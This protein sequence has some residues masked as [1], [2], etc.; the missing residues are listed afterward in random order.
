MSLFGDYIKER[1]NKEIVEDSTGFATYSYLPQGVYIQ[2]IY[3]APDY[4][5]AGTAA[6]FA[7]QIAVIAKEKGH[8]KMYGSVMPSA[9]GATSSLKVLLAYG[10]QLDS[11]G[12]NAIIMVKDI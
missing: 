1:E 4:R 2:D 12:P 10:F 8:T 6:K 9:K 11:A 5:H 3:V 7:D